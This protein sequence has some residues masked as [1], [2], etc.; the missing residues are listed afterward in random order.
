MS[1]KVYIFN[2][3]F[4]E[5]RVPS[6]FKSAS[7]TPLLK[8]DGLDPDDL[9]NFRPVSNVSLI[10]KILERLV[11]EG[12]NDHLDVIGTLPHVQSAY[13]RYHSTETVQKLFRI[14]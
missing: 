7:V 5:G 9:S 3:S 11:K 2:W 14:L 12:I 10:S 13:R 4:T 8:K 6:R 1:K